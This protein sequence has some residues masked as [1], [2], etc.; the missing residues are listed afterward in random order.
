MLA[1]SATHAGNGLA[2]YIPVLTGK[3]TCSQS[4]PRLPAGGNPPI[5]TCFVN[6][7]VPRVFWRVGILEGTP[8]RDE[9]SLEERRGSD[10]FG[11]KSACWGRMPVTT[12]EN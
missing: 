4:L 8:I 11:C 9:I 7:Q 12:V 6:L 10:V 1:G 5:T 3:H 2:S